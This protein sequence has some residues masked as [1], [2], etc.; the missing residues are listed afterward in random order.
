MPTNLPPE[1]YEAD[2]RYRG[3]RTP[4]EKIETLQALISTIPKHKG[5]DK[6]RADLRRKLSKLREG[7][8]G[9]KGAARHESVFS[10]ER[11]G[12]GTVV[13]IGHA[14]VGKS[15]LVQ[16]LTNAEPEVAAYPFSTWTPT[17]GMMQVEDVQIQLIDTPPLNRDFVEPEMMDLIRRADMI[18]L[19]VDL[20][21]DPFA[22]LEESMALL[23]RYRIFPQHRLDG[24]EP[25]PRATVVS[26]L[27]LANKCDDE[28][29]DENLEIFTQLLEEDWPILAVSAETG[30]GLDTLRRR[31]FQEL[32]IIRVYS[33][34][35]GKEPD[36]AS[37]FVMKA[38]GTVQDFAAKVHQDFLKN[39]SAAKVWGSSDFDGQMVSRDYVLQDGDVVELRA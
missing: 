15:A 12:A 26:L 37:P 29:C 34:V 2:E 38:G 20:H 35:P 33:K 8:K 22:Q 21:A 16:A 25:D 27:V 24:D 18:L 3:A 14:N 11:E 1:Y 13:V 9:R 36:L 4:A 7:A 17:P 6:L 19:L 39:L 28:S 10:I 31:V 32:D 30:R 5:T 23:E